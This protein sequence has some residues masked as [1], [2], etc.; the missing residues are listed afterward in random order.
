MARKNHEF[1][2]HHYMNALKWFIACFVAMIGPLAIAQSPVLFQVEEEP[3]HLEEFLYIYEKTNR[4]AAS[5]SRSSVEEYLDLYK[6]FKLKVY[7]AKQLELDTVAAL[8]AELAGYRKQLANTYLSDKEVLESLTKEGYKRMQEDV[9][10]SHILLK[11]PLGA[12]EYREKDVYQRAMKVLDRLRSGEDFTSVAME[13][14]ED[15]TVRKNEGKVG[16][17]TALLPDGFYQLE[18][19]LY[20]LPGNTYSRPIRSKLGYHIVRIDGKR[21]ARGELEVAHILIRNG[22]GAKERI[23]ELHAELESGADFETV[24]KNHSQ[25]NRTASNGGYLG[26]FGINKYESIFENTAFRI[27]EDGAYSRPIKTTIGWHIIKRISAKPVLPFEAVKRTLESDIKKDGR[28]QIAEDAMLEKIKDENNFEEKDWDSALLV[29]DLGDDF[30]SYKW[31]KPSSFK[32]QELFSAG[33]QT[34]TVD[35]LFDFMTKNTAAR[36]RINR[37]VPS[38]QALDIIYNDFIAE[39][40]KIFEEAQ[41]EEKHPEFKALMREYAEGIL[42]FEVTK[43]YVWDRASEDSTGLKSYFESHATN[44]MWPEKALVETVTI[45]SEDP[46]V[47]AK[48]KKLLAKKS[49]QKI[50]GKLN[51]KQ[52]LVLVQGKLLEKD[53]LE[54]GIAWK[55]YAMSMPEMKAGQTHLRRVAEIIPPQP[56]TLEEARGYIIADYQDHLEKEWVKELTAAYDIKVHE[57]VLNSIIKE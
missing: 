10:F 14:S 46:T 18:T 45:N 36:L 33:K 43:K 20:T 48:V 41:L 26:F 12:S 11:V 9:S 1:Q 54:S 53:E 38:Q 32:N 37:S 42:L 49:S 3:V 16:Y 50:I 51:K 31:I 21:P 28:F 24:A 25:D 35:H 29:K 6:K 55:K 4:D 56:K 15:E 39:Q 2:S 47:I 19:A 30:L 27:H 57:E 23:D 5:F 7:K 44:Y 8:N 40:L 52:E 22:A 17:V 34:W 13:V